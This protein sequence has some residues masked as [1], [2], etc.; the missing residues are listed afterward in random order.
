MAPQ[1][2]NGSEGD[3]CGRRWEKMA[4]ESQSRQFGQHCWPV[5]GWQWSEAVEE[6][7]D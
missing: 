4:I 1:T 2:Q 6:A 3:L 5:I 7:L